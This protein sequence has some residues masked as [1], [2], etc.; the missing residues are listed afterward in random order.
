MSLSIQQQDN[1][2]RELKENYKK[3]KLTIEQVAEDLGSSVSYINQ[4]FALEP[5]CLEDTWI[6]RNYLLKHVIA[7]GKRPTEF[8]A[9]AR[10]WHSYWFLDGAYI[11]AGKI[12][13]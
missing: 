3:A 1:T 11:D 12:L 10:D 9:L 7:N 13:R 2:R 8:T 6:L 4:L 5:A